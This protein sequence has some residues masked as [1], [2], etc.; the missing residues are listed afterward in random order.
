MP[1]AGQSQSISEGN[2]G[3]G[4]DY[5]VFQDFQGMSTQ[6]DR[7]ALPENKLAWLENLQPIGAN[8]LKTVGGPNAA[9]ANLTGERISKQYFAPINNINYT[10]NFCASG[11]AYAVNLANGAKTK[12]A[13]AGTFSSSPDMTLW[14]NE[15]ILIA[16][17][18]AG[19]STW[20]GTVFVKAGGVS[21]NFNVTNG[22]SGYVTDPTVSITGG[23]GTGATATATL[24]G[25]VVTA[26]VLTN[27]GTG[28]MPGDTLI[29]NFSGT[30]DPGIVTGAL[31]TDGGTGYTSAPSV[32]LSGGGGTGATATATVAGGAVTA[33]NI[34]APGSGYTTLPTIS[35]SG[36]GGTGATGMAEVSTVAAA[37]AIVWPVISPNPTTLA[38][39]QGRVFLASGRVLTYTGT[40]GYDDFS[41]ANASGTFTVSDADLVKAITALRTI[42][43]YLYIL[44]DNSVKQIGTL[45]IQSSITSF[46]ITPLSSDQGTTFLNSIVSYNRLMLFANTVGVYAVFGSSVEKISDD[47][48]GVFQ[49]IDFSQPPCAAV[50][51]INNIHCFLLLV[52]YLDPVLGERSIILSYMN[53]KWFVISQGNVLSFISTVI[54]NGVTETFCTSGSDITQIIQNKA[55]PV[56]ITLKTALSA[57]G[58]PVIG[59]RALRYAVTQT[60][61][62][63]DTLTLLVESENGNQTISYN[64]ISRVNW[65]NNL[66]QTVQFVN[67]SGAAVNFYGQGFVYATGQGTASGVYLGATLTG[68]VANFSL[69]SI[70]L[71][72]ESRNLFGSQN[73]K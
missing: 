37:T 7:H 50:N 30:A 21:P 8:N 67:N 24:V 31:V 13:D 51:D 43:N 42:G 22:G 71:E 9:T 34:T 48:D 6:A 20:D 10:I 44:G 3:G 64:A 73:I 38:V 15:R 16:D 27:P 39:F 56:N 58:N 2:S 5:I 65:I 35:F 26:L 33:I 18:Q 62:E 53:K 61:N 70:M 49:A 19:Y 52:R 29:V 4:K 69:N 32:T 1:G 40:L 72:Y 68:T 47:M 54:I 66:D 63:N 12:F 45:T 14:N 17:P 28:Y 25:G 46:T 59:K 23:T 57:H 41:T 60:V 55:A 11:S 36:G